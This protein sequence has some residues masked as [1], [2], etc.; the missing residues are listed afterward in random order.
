MSSKAGEFDRI[1]EADTRADLIDPA[2]AAAGWNNDFESD[3]KIKREHSVSAGRLLGG[4]R[5]AAALS[6]DYVLVYKDRALA[7]VEAKKSTLSHSEGVAQAKDYAQRLGTRIAY[8]TNGKVIYQIDMETGKESEVDS[9]LSPEDIWAMQFA[10]TSEQIDEAEELG[11]DP[12]FT[13]FW[14]DEL[15]AVP[16]KTAG[17]WEPRYYQSRA[18]EAAVDGIAAGKK[19]LLL[20]LATGTGK[21]SVAFQLAWKLFESRWTLAEDQKRRPRILFLADRNILANQAFNSFNAFDEDALVRI[22][23]S[24]IK[25]KGRVPKNGSVFFTIFQTFMSGDTDEIEEEAEIEDK[26]Y[27]KDYDPD[28]FDFI[29]IDECHRGGAN[30]QSSWRAIMEHFAPAVQLGLTA[31]P[32]RKHNADTYDYFGEPI[33]SYSLKEGIND[34]Y[35]TPFKVQQFSTTIDEYT[36]LGDDEVVSGVMEEGETYIEGD[37][38]RKITIPQREQ[39]RIRTFMDLI[40]QNEKTLVFCAT[41]EH[42]GA[43]RDYINQIKTGSTHPDYC[44]RVTANDGA[45]GE[46]HLRTFQDNDKTIP[47]ILTTSRKLST[48]VDALNIRNIV[49]LRECKNIIEFKQIVGRGTR[50]YDGKDF[51]TIY[52]F[53]KA[54]KNFEDP[55]WDGEPLEPE[56]PTGGK[57]RPPKEP[58]DPIEPEPP[59]DPK[60]RNVVKLSDGKV[61]SIQHMSTT[62]FYDASGRVISA[63]QFLENMCGD[64]KELFGSPD[65]L[66]TL[67]ANPTTRKQLLATLETMDY[68]E[69]RLEEIQRLL[70]AEG[71]DLYDVLA[72]VAYAM[73]PI[74]REARVKAHREAIESKYDDRLQAFISFVLGQYVQEGVSELDPEKLPA[75]LELKYED[76]IRGARELGGVANVK[77]AFTDFQQYLYE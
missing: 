25:K 23:P 15:G 67:W 8:A 52:D 38:N 39:Y 13:A 26:A 28:F 42:A 74:T 7:V 46:Q 75:L 77:T 48:G 18:I 68:S 35:L 40:D 76:T 63:Q 24:E 11:R 70:M 1:K 2:L 50:V 59:E 17:R 27:Y 22:K 5:R 60:E 44:V 16:F 3:T 10:P 61:R 29:I 49:L 65:A 55:E 54:Y 73:T 71:S 4:G 43:V 6:V 56:E 72:N 33:Y 32:K 62:R 9:Y 66:R 41:Q 36:Y 37:F 53:V 20:T 64:L 12:A 14:R 47:T 30:D 69:Q 34:G 51:F 31:T 45:L 58:D 19:R 21:T 57:P